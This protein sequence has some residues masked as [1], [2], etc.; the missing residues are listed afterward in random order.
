MSRIRIVIGSCCSFCVVANIGSI[1][2]AGR[3]KTVTSL[4]KGSTCFGANH[5]WI[6]FIQKSGSHL[7]L[8]FSVFEPT[9]TM[10]KIKSFLGSGYGHVK[11]STLF[12]YIYV[13]TLFSTNGKQVFFKPHYKNHRKF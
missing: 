6:Y 10:T 7:S 8:L 5:R 1:R 9:A 3:H 13:K 4:T 12:L 2:A 11:Q